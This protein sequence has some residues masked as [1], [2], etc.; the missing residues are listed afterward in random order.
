MFRE[1]HNCVGMHYLQNFR[2][3]LH[4]PTT[5][6]G[7]YA[8]RQYRNE[9]IKLLKKEKGGKAEA[10][11]FPEAHLRKMNF[12]KLFR[13]SRYTELK[14]DEFL[15]LESTSLK[16]FTA[17]RDS[18]KTYPNCS[19]QSALLALCHQKQLSGWAQ[20]SATGQVPTEVCNVQPLFQLNPKQNTLHKNDLSKAGEN[21]SPAT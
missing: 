20:T 21:I 2:S 16:G 12:Q 7:S 3:Q 11:I 14:F 15:T 6:K 13:C 1:T 4:K 17:P 8:I 9:K 10:N 5:T 19:N 18:C